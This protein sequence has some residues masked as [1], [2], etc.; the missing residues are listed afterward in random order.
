MGRGGHRASWVQMVRAMLQA[1]LDVWLSSQA[2]PCP[3]PPHPLTGTRSCCCFT[4][5]SSAEKAAAQACTRVGGSGS[6][7]EQQE[8]TIVALVF[9]LKRLWAA[10]VTATALQASLVPSQGKS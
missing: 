1:K 3:A 5:V 7:S 8:G 6:T 9:R 10:V 4:T 2:R